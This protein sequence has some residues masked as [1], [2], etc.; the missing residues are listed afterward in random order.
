MNFLGY[1]Q[2]NINENLQK[3]VNELRGD[4]KEMIEQR[5]VLFD[6]IINGHERTK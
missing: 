1:M 5:R 2:N 3:H 4:I 6:D